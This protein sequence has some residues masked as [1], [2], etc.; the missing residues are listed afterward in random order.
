VRQPRLLDEGAVAHRDQPVGGGGDSGVVRDDEQRLPGRA[1]AV[2]EPKH[3]EGCGA[4][5]V[6]GRFVGEDD[7]RL[8]AEGAGDRDPLTLAA[9]ERRRQML[10][11]GGEPDL[12][13]Q[14]DSAASCRAGRAPGQQVR[15]EG[16]PESHRWPSDDFLI[17]VD[18]SSIFAW[19]RE[20]DEL[21]DLCRPLLKDRVGF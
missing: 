3:V 12:L 15:R 19:Q 14:L 6:A 11:P 4:V 17:L 7:E 1:Q 5:E 13:E 2:Q 21:V 20:G 18:M 8:V 16:E 9:G 10:G